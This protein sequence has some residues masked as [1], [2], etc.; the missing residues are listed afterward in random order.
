MS[1]DDL[2][3]GDSIPWGAHVHWLS[4]FAKRFPKV[5]D[6]DARVYARYCAALWKLGLMG[7]ETY[8][9]PAFR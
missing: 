3:T 8:R 6:L 4:S 7:Y 1:F 2:T 9:N 5:T